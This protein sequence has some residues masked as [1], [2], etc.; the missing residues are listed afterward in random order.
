MIDDWKSKIKPVNT[1]TAEDWMDEYIQGLL[2]NNSVY[3]ERISQLDREINDFK[4]KLKMAEEALKIVQVYLRDD[5]GT[6]VSDEAVR[7]TVDDALT[8]ILEKK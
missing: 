7:E 5:F 1:T 4:F 2:H 8:I 6:I 3:R